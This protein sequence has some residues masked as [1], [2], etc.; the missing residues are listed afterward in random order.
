[1]RHANKSDSR[2][3]VLFSLPRRAARM[4]SARYSALI[5]LIARRRITPPRNI[6]TLEE[7]HTKRVIAFCMHPLQNQPLGEDRVMKAV[8]LLMHQGKSFTRE[9][10]EAAARL[11][12]ALVAL[13]SCPEKPE[14]LTESR[15]HL[16]DILVTTAPELH[17][18]DLDDVASRFAQ[19]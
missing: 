2:T 11:G 4:E 18:A 7:S 13:S 6:H 9:A 3:F 8:L 10:A 14:S 5:E 12:L 19:R 17:E 16:A 15:R 1:M